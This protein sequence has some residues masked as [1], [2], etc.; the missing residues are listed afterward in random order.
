MR[1]LCSRLIL[2]ILLKLKTSC[3]FPQDTAALAAA[4]AALAASFFLAAAS[5]FLAAASFLAA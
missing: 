1:I 2:K 3:Q 5:F 4:L